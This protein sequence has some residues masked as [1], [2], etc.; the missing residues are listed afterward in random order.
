MQAAG[1]QQVVEVGWTVDSAQGDLL[2]HLFVFAWVNGQGLGYDCC[3]YVQ[4][5]RSWAP[6]DH[7]KP[8]ISALYGIRQQGGR[9][10]ISY[11][12][13]R[14][15]YYPVSYTHLDVYKRQHV[16]LADV[17][18]LDDGQALGDRG[19]HA[20]LDA[21]VDHLYEVTRACLLYTSRCV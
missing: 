1:Q 17:G 15:G 21:V 18:V 19:H 20:V 9:W 3:G 10:W 16:R 4:T 12:G 6:G 13:Q 11:Q 2:P 8:G 7:V 5:G 14:I